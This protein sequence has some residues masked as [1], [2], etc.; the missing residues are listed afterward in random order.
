MKNTY[1]ITVSAIFSALAVVIMLTSYFPYLTYAIPAIAGLCI[2]V[3]LI[4]T[5]K[6]WA[7]FS[8]IT[9]SVLIFLL[10]ETESKLLYIF[11]FGIYP[12]IKAIVEKINKPII[13]WILKI[14]FLNLAI[15]LAYTILSK[16]YGI[17]FDDMGEFRKYGNIILIALANI[18]FVVYDIA[19]SRICDTYIYKL[20]PKIAKIFKKGS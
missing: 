20:H 12:I 4:E 9:S 18:V 3:V 19:I 17:Y 6:K 5:D 15:I 10:G 1:K 8:Y 14:L 7:L 16:L 13:E 11:F 2:M